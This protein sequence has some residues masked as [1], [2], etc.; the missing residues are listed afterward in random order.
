MR[1]SPFG[2]VTTSN[3]ARSTP[4]P[5]AGSVGAASGA[6]ICVHV[7]GSPFWSERQMPF[8]KKEAYTVFG[9]VGSNAMRDAPRG[10][11]GVVPRN[12]C[13]GVDD[14]QF[15]ALPWLTRSNVVPPSVE[16]QTPKC[17]ASGMFAPRST[18]LQQVLLIPR[19]PCAPLATK[20]VDELPGF[21]WIESMPRPLK[22]CAPRCVQCSPPSFDL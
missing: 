15:V 1:V 2:R 4:A 19:E 16:R 18:P 12:T 21:T 6:K 13:C 8:A 17:G 7:P 10:E 20:I 3:S 5:V 11:Q 14:V 22:Y 9:S